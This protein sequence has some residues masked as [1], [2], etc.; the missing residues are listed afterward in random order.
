MLPQTTIPV[1][2]RR[3][4][5]GPAAD[6]SARGPR[7]R[8]GRL[9]QLRHLRRAHGLAAER[10]SDCPV[11]V[12]DPRLHEQMFDACVLGVDP[13]VARLGLAVVGPPRSQAGHSCGADTVADRRR[14][15][16]ADRL[17]M[18]RRCAVRRR[19]RRAPARRP[20]RSSG[21]PGTVNKVSALAVARATGVVMVV[22]GRGRRS[23]RG[24]RFARGEERHHGHRVTP[25]RR[26]SAR[27]SSGSTG[28]RDVPTQ[29]DAA[30]AVGDRRSRTW[31]RVTVRR[32]GG[33]GGGAM[34]SFLEG[35][36]VEK[37]GARVVLDVAGVGYDVL[38]PTSILGRAPAGRASRRV[39]T[40]MVVRDD[41]MILYGFSSTDERELFD[42]LTGVTGVGPKVA[43]AFLSAL[44]ARRAPAR[45]RRRRRRRAHGRAG[46]R[47]EGRA[48]RRA[49]PA[50]P[51]GRRG[52]PDRR[53]S[54]R[55]R[56]RGAP[57][58]R[59]H[60]RGG[61]RAPSAASRSTTARST[62]CCARRCRRWADDVE[63][64]PAH[65]GRS[66]CPDDP[67]VRCRA[68]SPTLDEFVGPGAGEG[69]ARAADRRRA[70]ARRAGRPPAVQR[71]AGPRQDH[72]RRRSSRNEM[73]AGFQP[74]SGPALDRPSD[75]AAIL[76]NLDDGDVLFV[77]EI[78]RMPRAGRGGPVP[79][80]RGLQPRRRAGQGAHRADRSGWSCRGSR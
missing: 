11:R 80:A 73:G 35:E 45:G 4:P 7:R 62:T 38:V 24:V 42:L 37:T 69:A 22:G 74:T 55:R 31:L 23:G 61:E 39:H 27:R 65:R 21:S 51:L 46:R 71:A 43:L 25:T 76:T 19:D 29:P 49:R 52:R 50:R 36:V 58:A 56:A 59:A 8:P 5:A 41:A 44:H 9:R 18:H 53:G 17:Q 64:R 33:A 14:P 26:R 57:R 10:R 70:P 68:A 13:G 20:W 60:A 12:G 1:D 3:G 48:A 78:H 63:R 67:R 34:I 15:P 77:D 54:A 2:G 32:G 6:R 16:E 75:L 72:A 47:Q 40:R 66:R 30:D 28:S 79:G